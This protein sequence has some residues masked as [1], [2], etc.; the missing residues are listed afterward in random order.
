MTR[1]RLHR[2]EVL[3]IGPNEIAARCI[4]ASTKAGLSALFSENCGASG[5]FNLSTFKIYDKNL[6]N[7]STFSHKRR[8]ARGF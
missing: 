2:A 3:I 8:A 7:G 6:S 4:I 5:A 1:K